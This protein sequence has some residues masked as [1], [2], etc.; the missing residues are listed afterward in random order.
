MGVC[1]FTENRPNFGLS[2]SFQQE[3][4]L[5]L[6]WLVGVVVIIVV[7]GVIVSDCVWS[8]RSSSLTGS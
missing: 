4:M 3:V 2:C 6:L 7:V 5:L 8:V 1:R